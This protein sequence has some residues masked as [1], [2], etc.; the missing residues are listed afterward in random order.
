MLHHR[1]QHTSGGFGIGLGVVMTELMANVRRQS[2]EFVI[3]QARPD[4]LGQLAGAK[5]IKLGSR[6]IEMIQSVPQMPDV[7]NCVM[8]YHEVGAGQ[9][10]QKF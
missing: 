2:I 8:C 10:L 6:Q 7:E 5:I 3:W 9:P 1:Q 4:S